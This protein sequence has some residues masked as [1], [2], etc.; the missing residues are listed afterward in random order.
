MGTLRSS[1]FRVEKYYYYYF[2]A[3]KIFLCLGF[4]GCTTA[5]FLLSLFFFYFW[6]LALYSLNRR[7]SELVTP[8]LLNFR[9]KSIN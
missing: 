6:F 5:G 4:K 9:D 3:Y 2:F 1:I 7:G 8:F